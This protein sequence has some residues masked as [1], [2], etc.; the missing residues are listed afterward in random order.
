MILG[1]PFMRNVYTVRAYG[2]PNEDTIFDNSVDTRTS[3]LLGLLGLTNATE[4][5][6]EFTQV[7]V[8][9]Q[10]L[11]GRSITSELPAEIKVLIT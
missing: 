9:N 7:R 3:S 4:P 5:M 8:L 6:Q 1:V 11:G 10:P 2:Q